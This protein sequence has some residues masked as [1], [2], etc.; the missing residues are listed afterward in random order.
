[1]QLRL[2]SL[3]AVTGSHT[4]SVEF[5]K[6]SKTCVQLERWV[7]GS[8]GPTE[9]MQEVLRARQLQ[10]RMLLDEQSSLTRQR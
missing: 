2:I 6:T 9:G 1:M 10:L 4:L 5:S 3:I 7:S 8:L